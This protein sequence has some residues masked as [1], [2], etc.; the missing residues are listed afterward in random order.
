[1]FLFE[2]QI[3]IRGVCSSWVFLPNPSKRVIK[4]IQKRFQ[5]QFSGVVHYQKP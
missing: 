2:Y 1:M 4:K 3:W 5:W